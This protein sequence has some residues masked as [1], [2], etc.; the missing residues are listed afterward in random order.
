MDLGLY[1]TNGREILD[2]K[3]NKCFLVGKDIN[4]CIFIVVIL[5]YPF[6]MDMHGYFFKGKQRENKTSN[7]NNTYYETY[8]LKKCTFTY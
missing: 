4:A 5:L 6:V 8:F 1:R 2:C 3:R 7:Q